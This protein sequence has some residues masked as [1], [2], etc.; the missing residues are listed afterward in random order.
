MTPVCIEADRGSAATVDPGVRGKIFHQIRNQRNQTSHLSLPHM[1]LSASERPTN[2]VMVAQA[3]TKPTSAATAVK[4]ELSVKQ[5]LKTVTA[6]QD[7]KK[8]DEQEVDPVRAVSK[9]EVLRGGTG[10]W[11]EEEDQVVIE[12]HKLFEKKWRLY[13]EFLPGRTSSA[14]RN[15]YENHLSRRKARNEPSSIRMR[16]SATQVDEVE[17]EDNKN[18]D[19]DDE[20]EKPKAKNK[21]KNNVKEKKKKKRKTDEMPDENG[22]A[23]DTTESKR[24]MRNVK[25]PPPSSQALPLA[26]NRNKGGPKR[27]K[28]AELEDKS[29]KQTV[30]GLDSEGLLWHHDFKLSPE[31]IKEGWKLRGPHVGEKIIRIWTDQ[32]TGVSEHHLGTILAYL[33]ATKEDPQFWFNAY[34]ADQD[35]EELEKEDSPKPH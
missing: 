34:D 10:K 23:L 18:D 2:L 25:P 13:V 27:K 3:T 8:P 35:T 16:E 11:T 9:S 15:R 4:T 6:M 28:E 21:R 20:E 5:A 17:G 14:I 12:K 24:P 7:P 22:E 32:E 29:E 31:R 33:P 30:R 1:S 26:K 19:E